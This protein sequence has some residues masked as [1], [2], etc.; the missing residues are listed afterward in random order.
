MTVRLTAAQATIAFLKNQ[1]S[2]RDGKK[3]QFFGGLPG[4]FRAWKCGGNRAGART[5]SSVALLP[6]SQRTSHGPCCERVCEGEFP[7]ENAGVHN[8]DRARGNEYGNGRGVGDNQPTAG[9]VGAGRY[10]CA[11][12]CRARSCSN[13]NLRRRRIFP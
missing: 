1:F 9:S 5:R 10:L 11:P 4:D 8:F 2:E 12:Q 6:F 3:Y 13:W 7:E